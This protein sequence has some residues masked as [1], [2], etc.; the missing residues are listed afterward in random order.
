MGSWRA[1]LDRVD[2]PEAYSVALPL[3]VTFPWRMRLNDAF[4]V[5]LE[6]YLFH[7]R[8]QCGVS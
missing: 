6:S 7:R 2:D 1:A 4:S 5:A 8:N 3:R